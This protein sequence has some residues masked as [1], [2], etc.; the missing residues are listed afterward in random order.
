MGEVS[1]RPVSFSL[2]Q[3]DKQPDGWRQLLAGVESAVAD[4]VQMRAQVA[5]RPIGILMGLEATLH[6]FLGHRSYQALAGLPLPERVARLRDPEVRERILAEQPEGGFKAW[7]D[8]ALT[9]TF[10]LGDPPDYEPDPSTSVAARAQRDGADPF[11]LV[12]DLLLAD[13]G[14]ALLYYPFENY[15]DG[16]LGA[17][18]DMLCSPH[19]IAGLSDGGAHVGTICDA[20][21]PTYLLTHWAR[22]RT[23]GERLPLELLVRSQTMGPARAVG[24]GDRGVVAPGFR[25]DLNVV[26]FDALSIEQPTMVYD[27]PAGG[28]RLVQRATGYRHTLVAGAETYAS[29]EWTGA[30]PGRLVKGQIGA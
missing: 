24:L 29:C 23:R 18:H 16:D 17:V 19:T 21:F 8:H 6:P 9:R 28:R 1:G 26:D 10:L 27:L 20:S 13:D 15:A 25:A 5:S 7:M 12:Y 11:A 22:D 4:G 2:I 3:L 30:T 14:R